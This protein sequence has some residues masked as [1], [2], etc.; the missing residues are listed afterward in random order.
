MYNG[1]WNFPDAHLKTL[2]QKAP[3]GGNFGIGGELT[4]HPTIFWGSV[5]CVC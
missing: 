1:S 3:V 4:V 2:L 5:R